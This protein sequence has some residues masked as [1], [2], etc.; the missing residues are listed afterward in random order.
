M[1]SALLL[2]TVRPKKQLCGVSDDAYHGIGVSEEIED[3]YTDEAHYSE[4]L[5][6]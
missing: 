1:L 6:V 4:V 5:G 3:V 2:A